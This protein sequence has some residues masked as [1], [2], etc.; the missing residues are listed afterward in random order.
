MKIISK[1]ITYLLFFV[2][3]LLFGSIIA[4]KNFS[5]AEE[6]EKEFQTSAEAMVVM[7][8]STGRILASKDENKQLP[9][10]S[11]TK[12]ITAIVAIENTEDLDEPL[13]IPADA[14]GV[15]GSSIYLKAGEHLSM[16][17]LLYGLMLRSGNDAAVAISILC[18][19]SVENFMQ[20]C[21]NFCSKIGATNTHL[22]TPNGLHHEKHYSS[23][24]DLGIISSY[25]LKNDIFAKIVSTKETKIANEKGEFDHRLLINKNKFLKSFEGADGVKT[26]YTKKAGRCFVGSST[27][28][29]M[30]VVCVLLNCR[31]MFEECKIL[32]KQAFEKYSMQKVLEGEKVFEQNIAGQTM[33]ACAQKDVFYPLKND[34]ISSVELKAEWDDSLQL[35]IKLNQKVGKVAIFIDKE[36]ILCDNIYSTD[37]LYDN[38]YRGAFE[39]VITNF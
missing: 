33:H 17:E 22:V 23:A 6:Q 27:Q 13:K 36:L 3:A 21:N 30:Q 37:E 14:Q 35:P 16:R 8:T 24:K 26:G 15:E 39:K 7:E 1:S 2:L 38:S 18:A 29:G 20:M 19:G 9:M 25:A 32:C 12:I 5:Y 34:E 10:A 28:N 31:P 4:V 11:L